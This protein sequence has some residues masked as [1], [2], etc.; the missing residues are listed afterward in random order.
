MFPR[1][2]ILSRRLVLLRK[3]HQLTQEH[4]AN[5][6]EVSKATISKYEKNAAYPSFIVLLKLADVFE[7]SIDYLIGRSNIIGVNAE[8]R[9]MIEDVVNLLLKMENSDRQ[10]AI[11]ILKLLKK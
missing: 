10:R 1:Q 4:L 8:N 3:Q 7:V 6:L 5:L 9:E 2:D 11:Q